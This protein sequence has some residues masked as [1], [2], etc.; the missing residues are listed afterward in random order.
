[1]QIELHNR[2]PSKG[3][4]YADALKVK[5]LHANRAPQQCMV[6][7]Q[8]EESDLVSFSKAFVGFVKT[9][10]LPIICRKIFNSEGYLSIQ[11]TSMGTNICLFKDRE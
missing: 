7:F 8:V 9:Q 11:A 1:M 4:S 10:V 3:N 2:N 6:K 5:H